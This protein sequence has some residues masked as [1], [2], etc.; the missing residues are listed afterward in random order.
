MTIDWFT[1]A[2][3][4]VN[5]ALLL[6]LLRVFLYRPILRVMAER[7]KRTAAPLNEARRL[8]DEAAAEREA[9]R[10][11]RE[12]FERERT[13]RLEAATREADEKR[14]QQLADIE[15]ETAELRVAAAE[16]VE[17][18]LGR[19]AGGLMTRVSKLVVD[20]VRATVASVAGVE[21]D[22]P[23]WARFEEHLR[24]LPA[25]Q[26]RSFAEAARGAVRVVTPRPLASVTADTARSALRELLDARSVSFDT[27]PD[28][29]LGV[30]LE[31]GGLRLDGSA[32]AR[33]ESLE[34]S[35]ATALGT[36]R[37][38]APSGG[39]PMMAEER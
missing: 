1:L 12:A 38:I 31:A 17:R 29:L 26:R 39:A 19:V 23:A 15:R 25:E 28:L 36:V 33:L 35:F 21:L 4:L 6:I 14:Q 32:A 20:E 2:A 34:R 27:E 16:A 24:A 18:D 9:L 13:E 30:A 5:F 3:Q 22:H 8:A 10:Q 7:E 37:E 11:E